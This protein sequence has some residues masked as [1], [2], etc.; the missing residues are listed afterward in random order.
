MT[1]IEVETFGNLKVNGK[2]MKATTAEAIYPKRVPDY[3]EAVGKDGALVVTVGQAV[4]NRK[5][6]KVVLTGK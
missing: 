3:A 6:R 5:E 4:E 2:P 1:H